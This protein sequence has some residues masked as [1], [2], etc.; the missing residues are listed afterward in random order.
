MMLL[1]F[2]KSSAENYTV[3]EP[4]LDYV[5]SL[6][7][8]WGFEADTSREDALDRIAITA[9]NKNSPTRNRFSGDGL[10]ADRLEELVDLAF[11]LQCDDFSG[12]HLIPLNVAYHVGVFLDDEG[13]FM[14]RPCAVI[15]DTD[16]FRGCINIAHPGVVDTVLGCVAGLGADGVGVL[17]KVVCL[18]CDAVSFVR[19]CDSGF[20]EFVRNFAVLVSALREVEANYRHDDSNDASDA[21]DDAKSVHNEASPV[22]EC[23]DVSTVGDMPGAG[24]SFGMSSAL[25]SLNCGDGGSR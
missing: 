11:D 7:S 23:G 10:G 13:D 6:H 18:Y 8:L 3:A 25:G 4:L 15:S 2:F 21:G 12:T 9:G 24:V 16:G 20:G 5:A 19:S 1:E 17:C 22:V 14:C